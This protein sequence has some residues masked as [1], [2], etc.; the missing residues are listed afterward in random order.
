MSG[1]KG[2]GRRG[3]TIVP[4]WRWEDLS[5]D[6]Y[7]LRVAGWIAS[8]VD[9]Y[10]AEHVTRNEIA[11]RTG[12]STPKVS[13]AL[14]RLVEL[15]VI[16]LERQ[17]HS[18]GGGERFVITFDHESWEGSGGS[19]ASTMPEATLPP[20]GSHTPSSIGEQVVEQE[21]TRAATD[22]CEQM[23]D[24][25][26]ALGAKRPEVTK[27]WVQDMDRMIRI[28]KRDPEHVAKVIRW[29]YTSPDEIAQFWSA[30][31][32]SPKKL[33]AQWDKIAMQVRRAKN[34]QD[35]NPMAQLDAQIAQ[36]E[37]ISVDEL[38]QRRA[39]DLARA[40]AESAEKDQKR[41]DYWAEQVRLA[42][43]RGEAL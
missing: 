20:G 8:H 13:S 12:V 40:S 21:Q 18:Q 24:A 33:R 25:I 6:P 9:S 19:H 42:E 15:D 36:S 22:L 14:T 38:R 35:K 16:S 7:E 17:R 10:C 34:A 26:E 30:N 39:R 41:R 28:D 32:L 4:N 27:T 1:I 37:G 11:R 43:E 2:R 29:L 3:S 5:L 31:V 23:A